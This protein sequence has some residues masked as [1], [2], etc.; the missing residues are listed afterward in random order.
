MFLNDACQISHVST[1]PHA[2][3]HNGVGAIMSNVG[4]SPNDPVFFMHHGFIDRNWVAWQNADIANRLYQIN[5]CSDSAS[6]CKQLTTDFV[7]TSQGL[8]PDITVNDVMDT[9]GGYLC[10]VYD[11]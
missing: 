3:G 1:S 10:Y 4:L 5:G 8:R 2:Y 9:Q 11:A 6:P 7:L